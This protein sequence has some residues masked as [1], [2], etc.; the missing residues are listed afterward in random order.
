M[1][2][3]ISYR[4]SKTLESTYEGV[5]SRKVPAGFQPETLLKIDQRYEAKIS[6]FFQLI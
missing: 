4:F 2:Y 5:Q 1:K 3:K 6:A